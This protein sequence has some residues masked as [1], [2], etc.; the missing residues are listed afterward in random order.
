[1]PDQAST[2][3]SDIDWVFYFTYWASAIATILIVA[4]MI[5]MVVKYRRRPGHKAQPSPAH[6][7]ALEMTWTLIPSVVFVLIFYWGFKGFM[8]IATPPDYPYEIQVTGFQWGWNFQYPNGAESNEL[9]M[10]VD[11]PVRLILQSNDVIHSIFVPAFRMKKDIVPGRY[12]SIWVEATM[13][14]EFELYCAEYCGTS[15]SKMITKAVVHNAGS[16]DKW[17]DEAAEW[18]SKTPPV[19]AG[20]KLWDQKGCKQ[21]HTFD[22][23]KSTGPTFKDMFR[24]SGRTLRDGTTKVADE[25]YI[26]HSIQDP[27]ADVVAGYD[28]VMP[29]ISI[30]DQEITAII[31]WMKSISVDAQKP[32]EAWPV[33]EGEEGAAEAVS[34]TQDKSAAT[35]ALQTESKD[36]QSDATKSDATVPASN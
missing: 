15:H 8:D 24:K 14:G 31:E 17:L 18:V 4:A 7:T 19:E 5:L 11:R 23:S 9:H 2:Y 16:F 22:G 26:R 20:K 1:M 33:K 36:T 13:E 28:N 6:S 29:K 10:P 32:M 25:N 27:G 30:K 3:A 21:C 34:N 35:K 12:N